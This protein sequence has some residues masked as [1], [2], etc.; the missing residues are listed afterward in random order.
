L[1]Q[2]LLF[3]KLKRVFFLIEYTDL[4]LDDLFG[5][6][7]GC[8]NA[9]YRETLK[10]CPLLVLWE[11]LVKE[12]EQNMSYKPYQLPLQ[13]VPKGIPISVKVPRSLKLGG[14]SAGPFY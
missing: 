10:A 5:W 14:R 9:F 7:C 6:I 13:R 1:H 8:K 2:S 12:L 11:Y 3:N 4:D